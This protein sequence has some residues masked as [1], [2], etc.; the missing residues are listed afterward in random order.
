MLCVILLSRRCFLKYHV[1]AIS[2]SHSILF[3]TQP[4]TDS[5]R[6]H[7]SKGGVADRGLYV[8]P[9]VVLQIG[10]LVAMPKKNDRWNSPPL[11]MLAYNIASVFYHDTMFTICGIYYMRDLACLVYGARFHA[12]LAPILPI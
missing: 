10:R 7:F 12:D 5:S 3:Y 6:G 4:S 8:A 11:A 2:R 9:T 1:G